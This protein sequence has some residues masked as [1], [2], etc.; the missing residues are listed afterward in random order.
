M[1]YC[2]HFPPPLPWSNAYS[3][4]MKKLIHH[5]MVGTTHSIAIT[6]LGGFNNKVQYS[7]KYLFHMDPTSGRLDDMQG[8]LTVEHK[9]GSTQKNIQC[10]GCPDLQANDTYNRLQPADVQLGDKWLMVINVLTDPY[11]KPPPHTK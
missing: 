2:Y 9:V 11:P 3:L 7:Q 6:S 4:I 5:L 10:F 8:H 1:T